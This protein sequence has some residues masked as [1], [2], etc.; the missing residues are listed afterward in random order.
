MTNGGPKAKTLILQLL[1]AADGGALAA[2]DAVTAC[3]L[4]DIAESAAR[5]TLVRLAAAGMIEGAGRGAYRLGPA[6]AG[7]AADVAGWRRAGERLRPWAGGYVAVHSGA[8][9]RSDRAALRA[10]HRALDMLG[11]AEMDKGLHLRPDN[12]AGGVGAIRRRLLALGLDAGATVFA[13]GDFARDP[14]HLWD[15]AALNAA[16]RRRS[17]LDDWL[18]RAGD[19]DPDVA[20]REAFLIGSRAIR[21]IV[22]D[23]LLPE[24]LVDGGEREAFFAAV[25]QFDAAGRALWR[26]FFAAQNQRPGEIDEPGLHPH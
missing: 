10:R 5:V 26:R 13:A 2:R 11:F 23:P 1:L 14:G 8:L 21:Q 25:R 15:G 6:A 19:L 17:V 9:G 12:L 24:P 4:F 22:F 20:A 18:A 16:Y 3:S 7:F